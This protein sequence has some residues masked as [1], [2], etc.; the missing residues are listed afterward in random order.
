VLSGLLG[1]KQWCNYFCISFVQRYSRKSSSVYE[2]K[3]EIP[4]VEASNNKNRNSSPSTRQKRGRSA[5][6]VFCFQRVYFCTLI[7]G[8]WCGYFK[9]MLFKP[10]SKPNATKL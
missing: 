5:K 1:I 9:C 8:V 3:S 6:S 2:N 10:T 7:C 4:N